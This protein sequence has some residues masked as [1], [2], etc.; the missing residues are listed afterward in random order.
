MA[1][2]TGREARRLIAHT[3]TTRRSDSLIRPAQQNRQRDDVRRDA[4]R[5]VP[6]ERA[7]P[8]RRP[9]SIVGTG[10]FNSDGSGDILIRQSIANASEGIIRPQAY[11]VPWPARCIGGYAEDFLIGAMELPMDGPTWQATVQRGI[12]ER[13][14]CDP[15]AEEGKCGPFG[16]IRSKLRDL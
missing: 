5:L 16:P 9:R 12:F 2:R 7:Q 3:G 14:R 4:S 11:A 13:R 1:T 10:D 8:D 6:R 15:P